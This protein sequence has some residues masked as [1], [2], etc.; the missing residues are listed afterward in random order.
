M[1]DRPP[2]RRAKERS[3]D[4][5]PPLIPQ[6]HGGALYAGGVPHNRGGVGRL[7]DAFRADLR[8]IA[9][10]EGL[11]FLRTLFKGEVGVRF[12]GTCPKCKTQVAE[13]NFDPGYLRAVADGVSASVEHRLRANEQ[14]LRYGLG[15]QIE[16]VTPDEIQQQ[17]RAMLDVFVA[18]ARERWG[19]SPEEIQGCA[20]AM[21]EAVRDSSI[22]RAPHLGNGATEPEVT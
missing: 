9:A 17:A 3:P 18:W 19:R 13:R 11:P 2:R 6:E 12:V 21:A 20:R 16:A 22:T 10:A 8:D 14:A 15:T 4:G 5:N 1:P 7:R